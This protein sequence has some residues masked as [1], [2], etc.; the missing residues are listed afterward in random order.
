[1]D[2]LQAMRVFSCVVQAGSLTSAAERL[3]TSIASVSRILSS[4]EAHLTTRLLNR[5]TR[6]IALTEAG[7]RYHKRCLLI[8]ELVETAET[9]VLQQRLEMPMLGQARQPLVNFGHKVHC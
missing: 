8:L 1:M 2:V 5:T 6:R 7:M 4:L 3:D 9:E